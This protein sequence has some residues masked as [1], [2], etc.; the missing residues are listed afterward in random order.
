MTPEDVSV[1]RTSLGRHISGEDAG[2]AAAGDSS[3]SSSPGFD[4]GSLPFT[5]ASASEKKTSSTKRF[6]RKI[7]SWSS[8]NFSRLRRNSSGP[9]PS[10]V[11]LIVSHA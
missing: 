5:R 11:T 10:K 1:R 9:S 7:V 6:I 4:G 2:I 8:H 3:E